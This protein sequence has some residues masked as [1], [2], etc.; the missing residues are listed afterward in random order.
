ML[1][2]VFHFRVSASGDGNRAARN[3]VQTFKILDVN[4]KVLIVNFVFSSRIGCWK[5][6]NSCFVSVCAVVSIERKQMH[7][8]IVMLLYLIDE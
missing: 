4:R 1:G 6:S 2:H 5:F 3:S 7:L 8:E